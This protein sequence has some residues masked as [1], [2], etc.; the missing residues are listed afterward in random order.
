MDMAMIRENL[1][2]T[3]KGVATLAE[4]LDVIGAE[5]K[6]DHALAKI[7]CDGEVPL[8]ELVRYALNA[9]AGDH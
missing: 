7:I 8:R 5:G 9:L 3:I 2:E 4:A 6:D 1:T